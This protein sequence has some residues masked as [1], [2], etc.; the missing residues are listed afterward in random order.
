MRRS[1]LAVF[2]IAAAAAVASSASAAPVAATTHGAE[3]TSLASSVAVGDLLSGLIATELPGDLG[4]HSA[5]PAAGNSLLP[6]GLPAFTDDVNNTG[7]A[8]LLNDFPPAGAPSKRIQYN[9]AAAADIAKIQILSGNDGKDGRIYSTTVISVSTNNGGNFSPLGYFQSDPSGSTNAGQ[10]ASTLVE[11][12]DSSGGALAS[13]VTN[14]IFEFYAV[15]NTGGQLRDPFDGLNPFTG[16]DD[17]LSAAFV[18]PL[19]WEIDALAVP[20]PTAAALLGAA[21]LAAVTRRRQNIARR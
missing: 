2:L 18:S 15:D 5:N 20:E 10:L 6:T 21:S 8:G 17:G 9:L 11:I 12:T 14:L 13:G 1:L 16:V 4:W 3:S 7:L 19:I